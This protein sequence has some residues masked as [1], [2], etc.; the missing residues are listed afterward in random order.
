MAG[1]I[2]KVSRG[3]HNSDIKKESMTRQ[4]ERHVHDG[5]ISEK[6]GKDRAQ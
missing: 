6:G 1:L 4:R 5:R 2:A 3:L